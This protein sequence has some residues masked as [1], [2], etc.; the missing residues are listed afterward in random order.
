MTKTKRTSGLNRFSSLV[1]L[2]L[3]SVTTLLAQPW[4]ESLPQDQ[5]SRAKLT[6]YDYQKA[7][8]D[9]WEPY[10]VENGYYIKNG[11]KQKAGGWKQFHRWEWFWESRVDPQTGAFPKTSAMENFNEYLRQNGGSRNSTGNWTVLGPSSSVGGYVGLGRL[12]C[13]AFSPNDDSTFYAGAAAGGIWK[14][15]DAGTNWT[16]VGDYNDAIGVSDIA[17]VG[18]T[19]DDIVYLA[20]GDKNHSD[21]YSVGVLKS[22]DGGNSWSTTSLSWTQNQGILIYRL[23]V[24]P[25]NVNTLFAATSTGLYKTT[26]AGTIWTKISTYVFKDL[27]ISPGN[28]NFIIASTGWGQIYRSTNGG[29]SWT[30]VLYDADGRRTELAVSDDNNSR[31]YAVM[32]NTSSGLLAIYKST[33]AGASF[34]QVFSGATSNL[35][36]WACDGSGSD[37]IAWYDLTIASDPNDADVVYVGGVNNWKSVNAGSSWSIVSHWSSTCGGQVTEVHADQ[38]FLTFLNNT[39]N[40]YVCNDGGIYKTDNGGSSWTDISNGLVISQMYRLGLAQTTSSDI[41]TG[42]QD[43]GTKNLDES[44]WTHVIGGDGMECII[45]YTNAN[46]QYGEWQNGNIRRTTNH[47]SSKVTIAEGG[48]AWVTPLVMDPDNHLILYRGTSEVYKT[49]NQGNSWSQ[50]SSFNGDFLRSLAVAPSNTQYIYA[51][52]YSDLYKTSNGGT[53]WTNI[54]S[55]LPVSTSSITYISVKNDDPNT[56]W[57]SFS[58]Y[59]TDGVYQSTNGGTNWSNISSGLPLLPVNCVIQ[60]RQN[61]NAIELYAGTDVGVYVKDG[62]ANWTAFYDSLPY[63]VVNELEIYYD[64]SDTTNSR[65]RAATFGRG[66]WESGLYSPVIVPLADFIADTLT[67]LNIDTVHFTDLSGNNPT[68][69]EWSFDPISI[70]FVNGTDEN[71]QNPEVVFDSVGFYDVTLVAT[72]SGGNDTM[73]KVDYI[74]VSQAAPLADFEADKLNP[75]TNDTVYFTDWSDYNPNS[76]EWTFDPASVTFMDGT[77]EN[78]QNPVVIFDVQELY[79]VTLTAENS[80]GSDTET[81]AEYIDVLD[82]LQVTASA[83]PDT[84]CVGETT[85]LD[86]N[87]GG[88][89]G[90]YTYSWTSNPP[91]FSSNLKNPMAV[92]DTSTVY[93]VEVS[94]GTQTATDSVAVAVNDLPEITLGNWPEILCNEEEPPV[95]LTAEPEGG[96]YSGNISED[97]IFTPETAPQGWNIILYT[98]EDAS[99]CESSA[100]DSI[101]VDECVGIK[102]YGQDDG[103]KIYPN[104]NDGKFVIESSETVSFVQII[105]PQGK[106]VYKKVVDSRVVSVDVVLPKGVYHIRLGLKT[107]LVTTREIVVY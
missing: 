74:N 15:T 97:G 49:T 35:L 84:V 71:S 52:T 16:P 75:S 1:L 106:V 11:L 48:G 37:G 14:S 80:G 70:T 6:L 23:I 99:G 38:H 41:I 5:A 60:N 27:E 42:S 13:V 96:V 30:Q 51:A 66:L 78:S 7:F 40:L 67:P 64:D 26:D 22:A 94:D 4:T 72:N 53:T 36:G 55:G 83:N 91:G 65:I 3:F 56:L 101:F 58:G 59:D 8:Y 95:Q 45:D 68:E 103:I 20:T 46:I 24:K 47:W 81:K 32:A 18:T 77:D 57:L 44:T 50:I 102:I 87:A 25:N 76:W 10:G 19:T 104:P 39:S 29:N 28:S 89:S 9:Y 105:N 88:G 61:T 33:N 63:V 82:V 98:Y 17:V 21:T 90:S 54:T 92:P 79:D 43:N 62:M 31:V 100:Q 69:W 2:L 107:G 86:A 93:I 12:N 34:T 85:Q 73:T